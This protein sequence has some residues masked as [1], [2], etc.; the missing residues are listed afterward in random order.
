MLRHV[1]VAAGQQQPPARPVGETGPHLLAVDHPVVAVAH[2]GG[3]QPGEVGAG[4]WFREQLTPQ[5]LG[6]GQRPQPQSLHIL[7]LRVLTNGRRGHA[8]AHRI[9]AER[10]RP[11]GPLQDAVG[12]RL[13]PAG[14]SESAE[15]VGEVHPGQAGVI[16]G[17]EELRDGHLLRV[18]VGNDSPR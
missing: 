7:G 16:T 18:V 2:C 9:Q 5:I 1:G 11:A 6:G 10:Y 17:A 4:T 14:H 3:G 8:V 15:A 13:Q 12:D